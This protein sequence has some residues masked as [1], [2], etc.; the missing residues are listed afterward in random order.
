MKRALTT[1]LTALVALSLMTAGS[2][3]AVAETSPGSQRI[4]S[5][6][7][8]ESVLRGTNKR[9]A[10]P[11]VGQS[12]AVQV[13]RAALPALRLSGNGEVAVGRSVGFRD[14]DLQYISSP[15]LGSDL[16]DAS[17]VTIVLDSSGRIADYY[18]TIFVPMDA[19]SG[20]VVIWHRGEIAFDKVATNDG[21][22]ADPAQ[23]LQVS[24][25]W[26]KFN[27]C[28]ASQGIASWAITA[29]TAA[30]SALCVA[31][32]GAGCALCIS[33]AALVGG[34]TLA[35]CLGKAQQ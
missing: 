27:K 33:A 23:P 10:M 21:V 22:I 12:H 15:L 24:F 17:N 32:V 5:R 19:N 35:F 6:S 1:I 18:E 28:L 4:D 8:A 13:A 11:Q 14:G 2:P 30:C 31:T 29:I 7:A 20:R 9:A 26:S 25:S 34:S 3:P 16:L